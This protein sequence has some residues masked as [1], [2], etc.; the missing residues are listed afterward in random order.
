MK[1]IFNNTHLK[2]IS[3]FVSKNMSQIII[4]TV[5][6]EKHME[7]LLILMDLESL[8]I[9][10]L[11]FTFSALNEKEIDEQL[12]KYG[13]LSK[14][15]LFERKAILADLI[16]K[17]LLKIIESNNN[18][19][20]RRIEGKDLKIGEYKQIF[21]DHAGVHGVDYSDEISFDIENSSSTNNSNKNINKKNHINIKKEE[22]FE[23]NLVYSLLKYL[24]Q[25]KKSI[26]KNPSSTKNY[27]E[28]EFN[29]R[30][31]DLPPRFLKIH[32][33]ENYSKYFTESILPIEKPTSITPIL[34]NENSVKNFYKEEKNDKKEISL[35]PGI[36]TD[37]NII[38]RKKK[39]LYYEA[40][41]PIDYLSDSY[42]KLNKDEEV[43]RYTVP[44]SLYDGFSF[45]NFV[46][47]ILFTNNDIE[48]PVTSK[49]SSFSELRKN[50]KGFCYFNKF[51]IQSYMEKLIIKQDEYLSVTDARFLASEIK[52]YLT[53]AEVEYF[54]NIFINSYDYQKERFAKPKRRNFYSF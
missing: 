43:D 6:F 31:P 33:N 18:I 12:R 8:K 48:I 28:P 39:A 26:L 46:D 41:T 45:R 32:N 50:M 7:K 29:M 14:I 30:F 9:L 42:L 47:Q 35:D 37:P 34:K 22:V 10:E 24:N 54:Y 27:Y 3:E 23:P 49:Y 36:F 13:F 40:P 16:R 38:L 4:P 21:R 44:S 20:V 5:S 52:P 2:Y 17:K 53:L 19:I 11:H 1:R 15:N 25:Y 51:Y